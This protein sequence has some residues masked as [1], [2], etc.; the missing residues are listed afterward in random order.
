MTDPSPGTPGQTVGPFFGL[1]LPV[2]RRPELVPPGA[3]GAIR[4]H[5]RVL[6]GPGDPVPTRCSSSGSPVRMARSCRSP[7]R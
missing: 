6:D 4:L 7:A 2:P 1:S 5:G 3:A